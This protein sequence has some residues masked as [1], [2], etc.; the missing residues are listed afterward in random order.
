MVKMGRLQT[1]IG[2][3]KKFSSEITR[4]TLVNPV[5]TEPDNNVGWLEMPQR[6]ENNK[7]N[8]K[9]DWNNLVV[10]TMRNNGYRENGTKRRLKGMFERILILKI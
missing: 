1:V 5:I 6:D 3:N 10:M 9:R 2:V 7:T 8:N 4:I